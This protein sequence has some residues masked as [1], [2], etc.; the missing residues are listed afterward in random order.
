MRPDVREQPPSPATTALPAGGTM[1]PPLLAIID[2]DDDFS[3]LLA[4]MVRELGYRPMVYRSAYPLLK[5]LRRQ[6]F[7]MIVTDLSLPDMDG[8]ELMKALATAHHRVPV[9]AVS[10]FDPAVLKA[11]ELT[12]ISLGVDVRG[13]LRKP[14]HL[15]ELH[16]ALSQPGHPAP[17]PPTYNSVSVTELDEA[18]YAEALAVHFQPQVALDGR[19][20]TGV[21]ALV[22]WPHPTRG[23]LG[24]DRFVPLAE[25]QGL[26]LALTRTVTRKAVRQACDLQAATGFAG[27]VSVNLA[28]AALIDPQFPDIMEALVRNA[29][30]PPQGL[31]FEVTETSVAANRAGALEILARLRLKGFRLSIDDFGTGHSS[32]ENLA[33]MP[34]SE[35]KI[36]MKFVQ[37]GL[38]DPT[39]RVIVENCLSL[40]HQLGLSVVAEGVETQA[41]WAWLH[42]AGCDVAQGYLVSR[43]R[44][45]AEL[46]DWHAAWPGAD[47]TAVAA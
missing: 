41:Q 13:T 22:R 44:P 17:L 36:D 35:L 15:S 26:A 10:G 42:Q 23:L 28:P 24:P 16:A 14:F 20:W 39:A 1:N 21:E 11:A 31:C 32:L 5:D 19:G 18:I 8:F 34:V 40:G 38:T 45:A 33:E 47:D 30:W 12:G 43:P 29:G 37:A 9:L 7:A 3:Q 25:D 6:P 46:I 27:T 2:D 4:A